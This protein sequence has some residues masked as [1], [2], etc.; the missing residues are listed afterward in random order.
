M[1]IGLDVDRTRVLWWALGAFL[2][3]VLTRIVVA[4]VGTFVF[5]LFVYYSTR[6]IYQRIEHRIG[7]PSV[8]AATA[9]VVLALPAILLATYTLVVGV[10]ELSQAINGSDL[11]GQLAVI[12][13]Y[14]DVSAIVDDPQTLLSG[15]DGGQLFDAADSALSYVGLLGTFALHLLIVIVIAYYLLRDGRD[16]SR[17][18][19]ARFGDQHGVMDAF[20]YELDRDLQIVFFGNI[21]TAITTGVLGALTYSALDAVAPAAISLPYPVLLGL[22]TGVASLIPVIGMKLVYFPMTAYLFG[23]I[24]V[25]DATGVFWFP[26]VFAV[27]SFVIVDSIPDFFLR[28]YVSGRNVH[29][30]AVMVA[31]IVGPLVF[32]WYGLFLAPLLLLVTI[33]FCR[34]VLP[35]LLA[36]RSVDP[37]AVDP[38]YLDAADDVGAQSSDDAASSA[39]NASD[40]PDD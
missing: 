14:L 21:L 33:H 3:V 30:G 17:W 10:E 15:I 7:S 34:I 8:A 18:F 31:Y 25:D 19:R 9:L 35:E 22:L 4:F 6:P 29:L 36:A 20:C 16:L 28:P 1:A 27:V 39:S 26:I 40:E 38:G 24:V 5:A 23:R 37:Y 11:S 32:G 2:F 12:E 13:P